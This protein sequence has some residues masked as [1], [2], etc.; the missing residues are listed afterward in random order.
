MEEGVC[1]LLSDGISVISPFLAKGEPPYSPPWLLLDH[2]NDNISGRECHIA[3]FAV[4]IL[5]RSHLEDYTRKVY[6]FQAFCCGLK[7]EFDEREEGGNGSE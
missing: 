6:A 5:K 3:K 4:T 2:V 1:N 7:G